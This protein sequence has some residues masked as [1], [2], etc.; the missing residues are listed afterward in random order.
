MT[1]LKYFLSAIF[2]SCAKRD[3]TQGPPQAPVNKTVIEVSR[4]ENHGC[5]DELIVIKILHPSVINYV[6][7]NLWYTEN[8]GNQLIIAELSGEYVTILDQNLIPYQDSLVY[9]DYLRNSGYAISLLSSL[10]NNCCIINHKEYGVWLKSTEMG[11]ELHKRSVAAFLTRSTTV[12]SIS[13]IDSLNNWYE[14]GSSSLEVESLIKLLS[15]HPSADTPSELEISINN[16]SS[17][18]HV[19]T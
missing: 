12:I 1:S 6:G 5:E 13:D 4:D 2:M 3:H 9:R 15:G 14:T 18:D 7:S 19:S 10:A 16:L 11:H 17:E 8:C